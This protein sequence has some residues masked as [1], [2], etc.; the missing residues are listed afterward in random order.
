MKYIDLDAALA[1]LP[2]APTWT[3]LVTTLADVDD[4]SPDE[5]EAR[6]LAAIA[7]GAVLASLDDGNQWRITAAERSPH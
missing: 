5:A 6:L 4:W 2:P 7:D 3:A 1:A